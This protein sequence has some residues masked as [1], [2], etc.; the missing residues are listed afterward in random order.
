MVFLP[1]TTFFIAQWLFDHNAIISGGLAAAAA[2]VVLV[3][4]LVVAF[5]ET[6]E[7]VDEKRENVKLD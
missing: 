3:G 1:L 6:S 4:Y 7:D 2:N 5:S